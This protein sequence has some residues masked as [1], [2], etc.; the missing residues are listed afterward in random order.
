MD[1]RS[2]FNYKSASKKDRLEM[3]EKILSMAYMLSIFL[4]IELVL[5]VVFIYLTDE[6]KHYILIWLAAF[7]GL[8]MILIMFFISMARK[9]KLFENS[10]PENIKV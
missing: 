9:I 10:N 3:A 1:C 2:R 4:I 5:M 7:T 8:Q 6:T